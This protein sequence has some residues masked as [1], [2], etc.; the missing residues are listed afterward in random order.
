V[1]E[2]FEKRR[3]ICAENERAGRYNIGE[4]VIKLGLNGL[5]GKVA[6][7]IGGSETK[8]PSCYNVFYAERYERVREGRLEK[9]HYRPRMRSS[10]TDAVFSKVPLALNEGGARAMG[11][12]RGPR[13]AHG[14][15]RGV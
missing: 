15:E 11:A 10:S 14:T 5:S 3:L 1:P 6:Q 7:S 8:P 4:K 12:G 13:S 9:L 2:A